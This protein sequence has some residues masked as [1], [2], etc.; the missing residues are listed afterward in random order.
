MEEGE[1]RL[2]EVWLGFAGSFL[3]A[4]GI[5][6]GV[7]QFNRGEENKV[8][9]ENQLLLRKDEIDFQRR[10]WLER[11]TIYRSVSETAGKVVARID[12]PAAMREA[13]REFMTAYWGTMIFVED[14]AVEK[15]TVAF[16]VEIQDFQNG[17]GSVEKLKFR[18]NELIKA[19]RS[20]VERGAPKL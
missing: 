13:I 19:Y 4:I 15:A 16:F 12:D 6:F 1:K 11:L 2:W 3:T 14:E 10:L 5:L 18:A 7:W 20:S 17:W 9:L 8:R